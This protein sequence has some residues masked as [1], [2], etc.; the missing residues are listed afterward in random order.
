MKRKETRE[1][2]PSDLIKRQHNLIPLLGFHGYY[3]DRFNDIYSFYSDAACSP[4]GEGKQLKVYKNQT[5]D[6][7]LECCTL[8]DDEGK[9]CFRSRRKILIDT[10]GKE[11]FERREA[12]REERAPILAKEKKEAEARREQEEREHLAMLAEIHKDDEP[13]TGDLNQL[14]PI[15][16][17]MLKTARDRKAKREQEALGDLF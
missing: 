13:F 16:A 12:L 5:N 10:L 1:Y 7:T 6:R 14:D 4:I 15:V 8:F 17:N 3:V 9:R 11:E 2:S